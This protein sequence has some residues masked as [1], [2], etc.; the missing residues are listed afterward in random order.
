M[1]YKRQFS[2]SMTKRKNIDIQVVLFVI[3]DGVDY[4]V[5]SSSNIGIYKERS[6]VEDNYLLI[7]L[8]VI[9]GIIALPIGLVS[10]R[11][12]YPLHYMKRISLKERRERFD[13]KR[14]KTRKRI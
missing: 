5:D 2:G 4:E 12:L 8:L 9:G 14:K 7:I 11:I 6:W 10:I 13:K 3:I 1:N